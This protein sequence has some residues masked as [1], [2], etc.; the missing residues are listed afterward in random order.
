MSVVLLID[1]NL[2]VAMP[3]RYNSYHNDVYYQESAGSVL[4]AK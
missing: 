1:C 4:I 3:A 2:V